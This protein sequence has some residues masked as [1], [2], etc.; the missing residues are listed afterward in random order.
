MW[1]LPQV[2]ILTFWDLQVDKPTLVSD[3]LN[4]LS[5]VFNRLGSSSGRAR[6]IPSSRLGSASGSTVFSRLGIQSGGTKS[7]E[8]LAGN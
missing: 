5:P 8:I 2:M 7:H 4:S 3:S 1:Q 6:S